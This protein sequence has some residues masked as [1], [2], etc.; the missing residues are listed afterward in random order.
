MTEILTRDALIA[1]M[2]ATNEVEF[3]FFWRTTNRMP[4][5]VHTTSVKLTGAPTPKKSVVRTLGARISADAPET[6][7]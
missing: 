7:E 1:A 3:V 6:E 2:T 5:V 4:A